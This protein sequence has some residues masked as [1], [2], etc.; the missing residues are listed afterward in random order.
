MN[1]VLGKNLRYLRLKHK[2]SQEKIA[3]ILGYKSFTTIQKWEAGSSKPNLDK[4]QILANLYNVSLNDIVSSD[5]KLNNIN[6]LTPITFIMSKPKNNIFGKNLRFL[7]KKNKLSQP[8]LGKLIDK[9]ESTIQMYEQGK[10]MP[11]MATITALSL[12]FKVDINYLVN[13]DLRRNEYMIDKEKMNKLIEN[14]SKKTEL[15]SILLG[16]IKS[17]DVDELHKVV[18]YSE[19]LKIEKEE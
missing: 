9:S 15:L 13:K 17:L 11:I 2:Y 6:N 7:R 8:Q 3:E 1:N 19:K 16:N 10:R 5:L 4:L 12:I 14:D 18:D